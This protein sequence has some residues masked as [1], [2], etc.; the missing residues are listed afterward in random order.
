MRYAASVGLVL[1]V[2]AL[3]GFLAV[4]VPESGSS[5]NLPAVS[6]LATERILLEGIRAMRVKYDVHVNNIANSEVPA[7]KRMRVNLTDLGYNYLK[8]VGIGSAILIQYIL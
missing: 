8:R 3:S 2:F 6:D 1:A 4:D 5:D 7:F